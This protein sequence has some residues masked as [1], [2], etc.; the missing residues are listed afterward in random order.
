MW[1]HEAFTTYSEALFVES[2]FGKQAGQEYLHGQRR[3]IQNDAPIIGPYGVNKEGSGDMYDKGSALLNTLR[4]VLND[5][6]K[7]RQLLRG[8]SSTFYHQTVTGQQVIDYFNRESGRD[9]TR[10]FDQYLRHRSLPILEIR[11]ED[12]KTFA[13][14]V[15]NVDKF[16]MPVRVRLKGGEYQ[17]VSPTTKFTPIKELAGATKENLEVDTFN[18]YIGVLVE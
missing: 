1:V 3:N 15:A 6:A 8:I 7:W 2:Q 5:D 4:T 9:F 18:Y 10:V 17:F 12:G 11:F 14:W 13:R 16:D